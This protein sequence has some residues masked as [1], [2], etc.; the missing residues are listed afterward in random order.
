MRAIVQGVDAY[1]ADEK[2]IN[3]GYKAQHEPE[4]DFVISASSGRCEI[5]K[6]YRRVLGDFEYGG[7]VKIFIADP[8]ELCLRIEGPAEEVVLVLTILGIPPE[9]FQGA[10]S[11]ASSSQG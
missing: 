8:G 4:N 1:E 3:F 5:R 6:S 2:L 9:P 10:V 11:L 7:S